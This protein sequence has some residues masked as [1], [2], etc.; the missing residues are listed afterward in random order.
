M[1]TFSIT[2]NG[3][4]FGNVHL[5]DDDATEADAIK[6]AVTEMQLPPGMQIVANEVSDV[7]PR[8]ESGR[9]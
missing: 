9:R 5:E 2:I 4:F 6:A 1:K 8:D 3:R 7:S